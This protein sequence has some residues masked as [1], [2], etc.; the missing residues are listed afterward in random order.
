MV[1]SKNSRRSFISLP[2]RLSYFEVI[3]ANWFTWPHSHAIH[4]SFQVDTRTCVSFNS[5]RGNKTMHLFVQYG[6]KLFIARQDARKVLIRTE[7]A[8]CMAHII[9]AHINHAHIIPAPS[10]IKLKARVNLNV[11]LIWYAI[12]QLLL[13]R[14][15]Q[16]LFDVLWWSPFNCKKLESALTFYTRNINLILIF[17]IFWTYLFRWLDNYYYMKM[18]YSIELVCQVIFGFYVVPCVYYPL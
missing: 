18:N 3:H 7:Q 13:S 1:V 17:L 10:G 12:N 15:R 14:K 6:I 2:V 11:M 16:A 4:T 5:S 9:P 8:A